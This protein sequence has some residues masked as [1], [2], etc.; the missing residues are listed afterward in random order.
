MYL[1]DDPL[2]AVDSHVAKALMEK[3][4]CGILRDKTRVLVTHQVQFLPMADYVVIVD[5]G[6]I[7]FSGTY[8]ELMSSNLDVSAFV[9]QEDHHEDQQES[10]TYDSEEKLTPEQVIQR[11]RIDAARARYEETQRQLEQLHREYAEVMD[12]YHQQQQELDVLRTQFQDGSVPLKEKVGLTQRALELTQELERFEATFKERAMEWQKKRMALSLREE[13]EALLREAEELRIEQ[14]RAKK[15]RLETRAQRLEDEEAA[16]LRPIF[17]QEM[18][19][20]RIKEKVEDDMVDMKDKLAAMERAN[21]LIEQIESHRAGCTDRLEA[22]RSEREGLQLTEAEK[23]ALADWELEQQYAIADKKGVT[24]TVE[25]KAM[26][27]VK[28][29]VYISYLKAG[30]SVWTMMWTVVLFVLFEIFR[31]GGDFWLSLWSTR[32]I[33]GLGKYEWIE[34]YVGI[35]LVSGLFNLVRGYSMYELIRRAAQTLHQNMLANVLR[36][37]LSFFDTTP[38]GRVLNRFTKDVDS[39]DVML[40]QTVAFGMNMLFSTVSSVAVIGVSQPW[41]LV[42]MLPLSIVYIRILKYFV[43]S[44]RETKRLDSVNKSPIFAHFSETLNGVDTIR[45]FQSSHDFVR[46]NERRMNANVRSNYAFLSCNRWLAI[47]LEAIGNLIVFFIGGLAV[48]LKTYSDSPNAGMLGI[49]LTYSLTLTGTL[50]FLVRQAAELEAN[51]NGVERILEYT[52][53]IDQ[54]ADVKQYT[55]EQPPPPANWPATGKIDFI[56]VKLRYRPGLPLV[57][58]GVSMQIAGGQRIGI[59]GRTGSGKSTLMLALFRFVPLVEGDIL[60]DNM[61]IS[62]IKLRDLRQHLTIIPQDPVLFQGTIRTNLDPFNQH[63]DR[64]IWDSLTKCKLKER[65]QQEALG[66]DAPVSENGANFS[67]GQRQLFCLARAI[68]KQAKVLLLDEATASVDNETDRLIQQTLR[69]AFTRCTVL[70]I[71]HRLH[72]VMDYDKIVVM[73]SG[74]VSEYDTPAALLA[75]RG[76]LYEMVAAMGDQQLRQLTAIANG[77]RPEDMRSPSPQPAPTQ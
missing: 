29:E 75:R 60:I 8:Q 23:Q 56:N 1:L 39:V 42:A 24:M 47:R 55:R 15:S 34:I 63:N 70:T 40:A 72:T 14:I 31:A 61:D 44:L 5:E 38:L 73:D 28:A 18:E 4:I 37:P 54:E 64:D 32:S 11:N 3:C 58:K 50:N 49:G 41:V 71:A 30:G 19:L 26:G 74:R 9:R 69:T 45:A 27:S 22:I 7:Y 21:V 65:V 20:E 59:V 68:L 62:R 67:V 16:L 17:N 57:L 33:E 10:D 76:S 53:A 48:L 36:A 43:A 77:I 51:M 6:T 2:S 66:L 13:E 46:E 25:E 52:N 35:I 12:N